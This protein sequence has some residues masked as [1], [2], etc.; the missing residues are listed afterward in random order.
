M[1]MPIYTDMRAMLT[2]ASHPQQ[3]IITVD[4]DKPSQQQLDIPDNVYGKPLPTIRR[5]G[6]TTRS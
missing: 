2:A 5:P 4:D 1:S 3:H 6:H